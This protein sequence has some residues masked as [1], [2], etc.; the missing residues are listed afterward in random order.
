MASV[1]REPLLPIV[2]MTIYFMSLLYLIPQALQMFQEAREKVIQ[3][4]NYAFTILPLIV[5][6]DVLLGEIWLCFLEGF[7]PESQVRDRR[8]NFPHRSIS[9]KLGFQFSMPDQC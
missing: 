8:T 2:C 4:N 3:W 6:K 5:L 1:M 9:V 7:V